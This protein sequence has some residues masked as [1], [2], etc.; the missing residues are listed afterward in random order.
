MTYQQ[1]DVERYSPLPDVDLD[2]FD[3]VLAINMKGTLNC[4][5]SAI[6]V[7]ELQEPGSY[8]AR[9]GDSRSLG[10]GAIVNVTSA[11][12]YA[13]VPGKVGYITSKHAALGVTKAAGKLMDYEV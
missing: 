8:S 1:V 12:S 4:T 11:L 7:M 13:A 3:Q 2:D 6:K 10:R 9:S 5:R